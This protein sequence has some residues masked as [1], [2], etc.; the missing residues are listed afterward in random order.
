MLEL[1]HRIKDR[2]VIKT[3]LDVDENTDN[4]YVV[5]EGGGRGE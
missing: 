5:I 4:G 2:S 1:D 3:V